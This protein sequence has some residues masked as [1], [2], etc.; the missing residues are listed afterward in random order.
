METGSSLAD[1]S[2]TTSHHYYGLTSPV[3]HQQPRPDRTISRNPSSRLRTRS[4]LQA[5][6]RRVSSSLDGIA[7]TRDQ[8]PQT[9]EMKQLNGSFESLDSDGSSEY[10]ASGNHWQ[11]FEPARDPQKVLFAE[12]SPSEIADG[13]VAIPRLPFPLI[14]LPQAAKLQRA[15]IERGEEDHTDVASSF[16]TRAYSETR[17]TISSTNSPRTPH[18]LLFAPSHAADSR[19]HLDK[20]SPAYSRWDSPTIQG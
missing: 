7:S 6:I 15:R 10:F 5:A 3:S 11:G 18:S 9:F 16:A 13:S 12:A 20:P 17:S 2:D 14:S 8:R 19:D 4:R 1:V